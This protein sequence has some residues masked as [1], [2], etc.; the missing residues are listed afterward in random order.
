MKKRLAVIILFVLCLTLSLTALCSCDGSGGDITLIKDGVAQFKVV[1][2]SAAGSSI[3]RAANDFVSTLSDLGVSV[4][5]AVSDDDTTE[6]TE[7]EIII[8]T[9][10]QNRPDECVIGV[11]D[12]GENG[13]VIKAVGKRVVIAAGTIDGTKDAIER[14]KSEHLGITEDTE[15]L[16]S[17]SVKSDLL[18]EFVTSN[19]IVSFDINGTQISEFKIVTSYGKDERI[20]A[21]CPNPDKLISA[22]KDAMDVDLVKA[23]KATDDGNDIIIRLVAEA[24]ELL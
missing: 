23:D 24:G 11:D 8:G 15:S 18:D 9:D 16:K 12:I 22:I 5:D 13:Y 14:F 4:A 2:S 21:L 6:L 1:Y 3:R 20:A 17:A 19:S 7:C 10:A